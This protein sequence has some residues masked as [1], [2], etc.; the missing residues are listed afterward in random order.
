MRGLTSKGGLNFRW[1]LLWDFIVISSYHIKHNFYM[2][3]KINKVDKTEND[4]HF[5]LYYNIYLQI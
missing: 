1:S 2:K 5:F 3:K 4:S